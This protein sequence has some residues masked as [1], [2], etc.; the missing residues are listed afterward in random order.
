MTGR[1][2]SHY[3]IRQKLGAG[4]MGEIYK[5]FDHRL[6]RPVAIKIMPA[7]SAASPDRRRRFLQEAQAASALNHPNIITIYDI[8]SEHDTELIVMEFIDGQTLDGY[9]PPHGMEIGKVLDYAV[10]VADALQ[11]AHAA[12]IVHRD[13]KPANIMV[14]SG[15][16]VKVLDFGL[17]KVTAGAP[18]GQLNATTMTAEGSIL[19]TV[20]YMSPEQ[21]QG[22]KVDA[23]SDIFSFGLV[24]YEMATGQRAFDS[25]S[26]LSTLAAILRD[27]IKPVSHTVRGAPPELD[28][29]IARAVRKNP[30]ERWPNMAEMR[31]ALNL[32]KHRSDPTLS[33]R[34]PPP[35]PIKR[36]PMKLITAIGSVLVLGLAGAVWWKNLPAPAAPTPQPPVVVSPATPPETVPAPPSDAVLTNDAILDMVKARVPLTVIVSQMK[37]GKTKFDLSTAEVIRLSREGVPESIIEAMRDPA[38]AK[39]PSSPLPVAAKPVEKAADKVVAIPPPSAPSPVRPSTGS[40][41]TV[42]DGVPFNIALVDDVPTDIEAGKPIR[43]YAVDGLSVGGIVVIPKGAVVRGAIVEA[44]KKKFLRSGRITFRLTDVLA[45]DGSKLKIR[46]TPVRRSDSDAARP[47]EQPGRK[48]VRGVAAPAQARYVAYIEGDHKISIRR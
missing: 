15:G 26:T 8:L 12:G 22:R 5:A 2:I 41:V 9:I 18:S 20:S 3:D 28:N 44:N 29:I 47:L 1:T 21:A 11:A 6:N 25:D 38:N 31:Q 23:R 45:S 37:A 14:T 48:T 33:L 30:D 36:S 19:G 10:Q 35:A 24:V 17:A 4:G 27:D 16:L 7:D 39:I 42:L 34:I 43:F 32:L 13:L 46:T 40:S